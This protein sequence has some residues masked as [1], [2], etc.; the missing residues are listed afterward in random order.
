VT[1][2]VIYIDDASPRAAG[3]RNLNYR[4]ML[5][6]V[7]AWERAL[8]WAALGPG[9][10]LVAASRGAV[11]LLEDDVGWASP[12]DLLRLF[13]SHAADDAAGGDDGAAD[14]VATK[15]AG[16]EAEAPAWPHWG[17]GGALLPRAQYDLAAG[18]LALCRLSRRLLDALARFAAAHS[19]LGYLEL[20]VPTLA[21]HVGLRVAWMGVSTPGVIASIQAG[22]T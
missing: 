3:I 11:W 20:L 22:A 10:P 1:A 21:R 4:I 8:W 9:A 15:A 18:F 6:E 17:A 5:R 7:T 14:L 19:T 2:R 12:C 13:D 16:S